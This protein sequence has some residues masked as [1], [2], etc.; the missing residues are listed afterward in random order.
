VGKFIRDLIIGKDR[1]I[2]SHG[3]YKQVMLSGQYALI[4]IAL[5]L[6]YVTVDLL[7]HVYS[8]S[9]VFILSVVLLAWSIRLHRK[10]RHCQ[11]KYFLL[12]T[13]N[14][15]VYLF[16]S[17]ESPQTGIFI[18][19]ISASISAFAIFSYKQRLMSILFAAFT[20]VLFVFAYFVDFSI[21]PKRS[22]SDDMLLFNIVINFTA[23]LPVSAMSIYL[24]I[25]LNHYNS[26]QLMANNKMLSKTNAELDRFVYST[27]HDLRAPLASVLG[28]IDITKRSTDRQEVNRYLEMMTGRI[29]ALDKFVRDITDYSQNNRLAV[30]RDRIAL[31]ELAEDV[32]ESLR[33]APEAININFFVDVPDET[34][35]VSDRKRLSI[36]LNNLISNAIRYHDARK[37][38]KFIRLQY[39]ANGKGFFIEVKDNGIGIPAE[40]HNKIFEMFF[41]ANERS[42]G[43]GLGLYIVRETLAKLSANI[44]LESAPGKG[45]SFI[46]K[47]P[48]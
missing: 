9:P 18:F 45:S 7:S 28:L 40:Y 29:H 26:L 37:G 43:S 1:F 27:S 23:A 6:V 48:Y 35:I 2:E 33:F 41:R 14:I 31:R 34:E 38:D 46:L 22:Y 15:M 39:H 25:S 42:P 8:T 13:I 12:L 32:W 4:S 16:A 10:G 36:V 24:M 3:E 20:Y 47:F 17:S 11:A 30:K 44:Q 21:L 5:C 19:F